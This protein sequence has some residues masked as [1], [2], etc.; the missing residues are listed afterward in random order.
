MI[1]GAPGGRVRRVVIR[2]VLV[3]VV[4]AAVLAPILY[5]ASTVDVRPPQVDRF[6]LTQHL[7]GDDSVALT[8]ASLEVVFSETVDHDAA[9]AAFAIAP[10]VGGTF[11][12]SGFT[13]V[14]TPAERLPLETDFSVSLRAGVKDDSG[15]RMS[16]AGPFAFRTVGG[17]S[18]VATRPADDGQDVALD[19]TIQL[20]FSTL[21]DTLS[22]QRALQVIPRTHVVLNWSGDELTI[23]P[24]ERLQPGQTYIVVLGA[25]ARDTAGT[26]LSDPLRL[27]F[28]T[29]TAGL[30]T[31]VVVPADGAQG[32]AVT[33]PIAIAFDRAID[34]ITVNDRL[35]T[36]SPA[37]SG[38]VTLTQADGA[39]RLED[40][41][42]RVVRFTPSG[43]LP[44][45]TTFTVTLAS[46]VRGTDGALLPGPL[47]WRFTTG[48]PSATLGNQVVFLSERSG[49]ANLWAMNPDGSNQHQVSA[50]LSPITSYAVSPDGRSFVV[51]DGVR[52]VQQ[53]AD[54]SNRRVLTDQGAVEYDPVFSPDGRFIAFGRADAATGSGLGL[55]R[56][57]AGGGSPER[58]AIRGVT[59]T[60]SA[61]P[62]PSPSVSPTASAA[63][64]ALLRAPRFSAD[65]DRLAFVDLSGSVG[66]V[67]L[68]DESLT[69]ARFNAAAP[70]AWLPDG[71]T[72]LFSGLNPEAATGGIDGRSG[73]LTPGTAVPPLTPDGL[74]LTGS[75]RN[76]LRL[77]ELRVGTPTM[78]IEPLPPAAA[79]PEVDAGGRIAY[80][81][82]D[83]R[84]PDAGRIWIASSQNLV[85]IQVVL[86]GQALESGV[87]FAPQPDSLVISRVPSSSSSTP[88]PQPSPSPAA[89]QLATPAPPPGTQPSLGGIWLVNQ[90][91]G[92]P[93]QL[94][95]DG[96]LARWLP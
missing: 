18:V 69:S 30:T 28:T 44:A 11:S 49:M 55:W 61:S 54:G 71:V 63:P 5:Y 47:T 76:G 77:A 36:I 4:G 67:D 62:T 94:S 14:F 27:S 82:L 51:G 70:P 33:S 40:D 66:I 87:A 23:R 21:M 37:V 15:N 38:G 24:V 60:P 68:R 80:L 75:Q 20:T 59:Q 74:R 43:T 12:W 31:R 48:S 17:P 92:E 78:V 2:T 57:P 52:L 95:P 79:L 90:E 34:P 7:P 13:M 96:W 41:S 64:A 72:A 1:E 53:A 89:S 86:P 22:V 91:S 85:A 93:V 58:V 81:A 42:R 16:D 19:A 10:A 73:A 65:G 25:D 39:A 9:Q 46:S 83:P 35:V 29:I 26:A 3:L 84:R 50:E 6:L 45:N 88:P 56:R 8:T 32:I